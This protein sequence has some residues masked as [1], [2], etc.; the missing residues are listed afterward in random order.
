MKD[1]LAEWVLG[2]S[3]HQRVEVAA[4]AAFDEGSGSYTVTYRGA[5]VG[6]VWSQNGLRYGI[7]DVVSVV[8]EGSIV[9]FIVP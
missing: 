4:I 9:K 7:G 3:Q 5:S 2:K 6:P 1:W 8:L